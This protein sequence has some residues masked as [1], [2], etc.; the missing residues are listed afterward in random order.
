MICGIILTF[1]LECSK[2]ILAN[3]NNKVDSNKVHLLEYC[4]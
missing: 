4:T 1:N 2:L 3:V